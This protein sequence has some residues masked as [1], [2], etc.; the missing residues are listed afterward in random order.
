MPLL[1]RGTALGDS[2]KWSDRNGALYSR[3]YIQGRHV[4]GF[5]KMVG[6]SPSSSELLC[7]CTRIFVRNV[8]GHLC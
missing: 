8:G 6:V 5:V 3:R 1:Y 7:M 4:W 2:L